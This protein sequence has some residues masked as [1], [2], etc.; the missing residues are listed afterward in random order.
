MTDKV[1]RVENEEVARANAPSDDESPHTQIEQDI[2]QKVLS[3]PA[4]HQIVAR[5]GLQPPAG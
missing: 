2:N 1:L 5:Y 3:D 4:V